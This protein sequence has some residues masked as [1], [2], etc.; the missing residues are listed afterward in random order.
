VVIRGEGCGQQI[1]GTGRSGPCGEVGL[2]VSCWAKAED[3]DLDQES[4]DAMLE[5]IVE[6]DE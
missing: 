5:M 4:R 6:D 1:G 2:C 3:R